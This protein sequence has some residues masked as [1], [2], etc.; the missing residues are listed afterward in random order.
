LSTLA[1]KKGTRR[2]SGSV[3]N[4]RGTNVAMSNAPQRKVVCTLGGRWKPGAVT[5]RMSRTESRYGDKSPAQPTALN[6]L[7]G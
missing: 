5:G 1:W 6:G 4:G 3:S 2:A 7:R